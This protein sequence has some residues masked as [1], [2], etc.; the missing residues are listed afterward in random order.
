MAL[1]RTVLSSG[2]GW[3]ADQMTWT[4]FF[5]ATT[6]AAVPGLVLLVWMIRTFPPSAAAADAEHGERSRTD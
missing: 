1:S 2:A 4:S 5:I 6:L 3:L